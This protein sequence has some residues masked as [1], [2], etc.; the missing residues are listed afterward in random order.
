M[1]IGGRRV[2]RGMLPLLALHTVSEYYRLERKPPVTAGLLAA[3]T[4]IYLRPA[5]LES[6]LPSINEVWFNAHLILKDTH[7]IA[8]FS[9]VLGPRASSKSIYEKELMAIVFAILKW[10]HYLLGS[11]FVV[12]TDQRSLRFIWEQR[13]IGADYQKWILKLMGYDFD[14]VYNPGASNRVADALSRIPETGVE[15]SSMLSTHGIQWDVL[16]Q[17]VKRDASL[18]RIRQAVENNNAVPRGF[19]LQGD[20]LFYKGRYVLSH[21]SPFIAVLLQEYHDSPLG[22]HSGEF[23]TYQRLA[24]EWFWFGMRKQVRKYVRECSTCQQQKASQCLPAGLL[25]PL[26]IPAHVWSDIS[27]DFVEGLPTSKGVN[28]V[29]VVVDRLT[30]YAHFIPLCHPF[31]AFSVAAVFM[32]EVVRLHGFPISIVS[33]RDRIFLSK[34]SKELF[35]LQHTVLVRSTS[36]HPQTDGQT[37]IVNK[38]LETYLRCY[39]NG[40]PRKWAA[41]IPWAEFCYN[42]S[43]HSS[44]LM[45]PFQ[46]LYGRPPPHLVRFNEETTVES[47]DQLL[48]ERDAIIDELHFNLAQAQQM[49]KFY[50]DKNRRELSFEEGDMVYLK[51]QPYRQRSLA[52]RLNEKLAPRFYGPYKVLQRIGKVAYKLDLP[53]TCAIHPTFHVSQL[54]AAIGSVPASNIP[55]H[56]TA[57]LELVAQPSEILD[58]RNRS[59]DPEQAE[60]LVLWKDLPDTDASWENLPRMLEAFPSHHLEDKVSLLAPVNVMHSRNGK[61]MLTYKRRVKKNSQAATNSVMEQ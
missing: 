36:F 11:K 60:I 49:M 39:I 26:P 30:K 43:P 10:K 3:N 58:I 1:D 47:L 16:Q 22:G 44:T 55:P 25:Q 21:S 20:K 61:E 31:T 40:Q 59:S 54:K 2:S 14:I 56:L 46:A 4:L 45:S 7:P 38:T 28:V 35:R 15:Y 57:D 19:T 37:E 5:F 33:D 42:T 24:S 9:K 13:E 34:F 6:I 8:F 17:E 12:K 50:A 51:L 27:M 41:W 29:L 23:K 48:S 53:D 32:K 18:M 52:T